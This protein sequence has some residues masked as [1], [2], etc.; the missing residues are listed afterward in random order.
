M[1]PLYILSK[2]KTIITDGCPQEFILIDIARENVF[3]NA[4]HIKCGFHLVRIGWTHHIM[5]THCFPTSD[6]YF[7][8]RV[9]NYM[10]KWIYSWMKNS[11]VTQE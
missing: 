2:V 1:L 4:L 8:D 6:G 11:F 7:Y 3:N 10:E 9:C 5:K